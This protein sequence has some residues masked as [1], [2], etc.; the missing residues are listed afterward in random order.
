MTDERLWLWQYPIRSGNSYRGK[1]VY[2][3]GASA[4]IGRELAF[5]LGRAGAKV[6]LVAR[7]EPLLTALAYE[8]RAAGGEA[9]AAAADVGSRRRFRWG[10]SQSSSAGRNNRSNARKTVFEKG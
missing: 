8:V 9:F 6:A 1:V 10:S 4:G 3:T 2:L 5:A 7:R